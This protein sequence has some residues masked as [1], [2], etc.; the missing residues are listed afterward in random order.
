[1]A[2]A[3]PVADPD[4]DGAAAGP[5]ADDEVAGAAVIAAGRVIGRARGVLDVPGGPLLMVDGDGREHLI[6]YRA[7]I[8]VRTDR[9]RREITI[10]P[11]PGLLEL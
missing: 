6:P 1:V 11:P 5:L 7:P 4:R 9:A 10:D 2:L 8:L 3:I